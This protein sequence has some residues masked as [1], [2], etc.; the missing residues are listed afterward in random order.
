MKFTYFALSSLLFCANIAWAMPASTEG[1]FNLA[2]RGNGCNLI[3]PSDDKICNLHVRISIPY[4][5]K[6]W[7]CLRRCL[8]NALMHSALTS[9]E[10]SVQMEARAPSEGRMPGF[11][12]KV[13]VVPHHS[14]QCFKRAILTE[15]FF[16][17]VCAYAFMIVIVDVEGVYLCLCQ[18]I[19][20]GIRFL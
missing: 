4:S 18:I 2:K 15:L 10:S 14:K 13:C 12:E 8:I 1:G 9:K 5:F 7:V 16:E 17:S 3:R 6:S 11:P 19:D 20:E